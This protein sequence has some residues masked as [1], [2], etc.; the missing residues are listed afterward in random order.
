MAPALVENRHFRK[1]VFALSILFA[2]FSAAIFIYQAYSFATIGLA[3]VSPAPNAP[4]AP[5]PRD[6]FFRGVSHD[7]PIVLIYSFFG[8][9]ISVLAAIV[10]YYGAS[11]P[12]K[13]GTAPGHVN[14]KL[15]SDAKRLVDLLEGNNGEMS[16]SELVKLSGMNKLRVSRILKRLER[17][18]LIKKH[19]Y[20]M[21]NSITLDQGTILD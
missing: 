4:V 18:K 21:T 13:K 12:G 11:M 17:L 20:G 16:Q 3:P 9:V 6:E 19:P 5:L 7:S 10:I 2:V 14:M 8:M 15:P 1:A